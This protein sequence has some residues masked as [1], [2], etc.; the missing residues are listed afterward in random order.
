MRVRIDHLSGIDPKA[1]QK[2]PLMRVRVHGLPGDGPAAP[3][4]RGGR[5]GH[6]RQPKPRSQPRPRPLPKPGTRR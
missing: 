3:A 5:P 2:E 1:R 4:G 6:I